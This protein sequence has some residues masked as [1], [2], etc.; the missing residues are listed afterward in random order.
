ML[1]LRLPSSCTCHTFPIAL[2][3]VAPQIAGDPL[4]RYPSPS[5][6][7]LCDFTGP[8]S[9]SGGQGTCAPGSCA[10]AVRTGSESGLFPLLACFRDFST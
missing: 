6:P 9:T 8:V 10:G 4:W 2:L 7:Y 1:L 5:T 3:Q